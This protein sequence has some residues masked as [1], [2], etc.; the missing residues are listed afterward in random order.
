MNLF[1][2]NPDSEKMTMAAIYAWKKGLKTLCY[3]TRVRT[4]SGAI[5]YT[6]DSTTQKTEEKVSEIEKEK[7]IKEEKIKKEEGFVCTDDVCVMCQS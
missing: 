1:F 3:Y 4:A 2:S 6:V 7:P 5:K